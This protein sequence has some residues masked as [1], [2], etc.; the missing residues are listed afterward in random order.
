MPA[1]NPYLKM[2]YFDFEQVQ[3]RVTKLIPQIR[4]LNYESRLANLGLETLKERRERGDLIQFN[5]IQNKYNHV[6]WNYDAELM[7]SV[8]NE[9]PSG[10]VRGA[11]HRIRSQLT[12]WEA[13]RNFLSN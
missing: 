9:G 1:W 12:K 3:R 10:G 8:S 7:I 2:I 6:N 5:K 4:S 13:R 11:K